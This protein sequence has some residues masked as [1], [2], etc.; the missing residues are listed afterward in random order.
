MDHPS[1]HTSG[2]GAPRI[3][4]VPA[5]G[6]SHGG[7]LATG[8]RGPPSAAEERAAEAHRL[9]AGADR[10]W[11]ETAAE[12]AE[13]KGQLEDVRSRLAEEES[14]VGARKSRQR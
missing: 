8:D 12:L 10:R 13:T 3:E 4:F 1:T 9:A 2:G 14:K 7:R 6:V 11:R 5:V